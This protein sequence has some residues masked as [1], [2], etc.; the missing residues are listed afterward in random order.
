MGGSRWSSDDYQSYADT[1][2]YRTMSREQVFSHKVDEKLDPRNVK[3]GK[4]ERV[5]LQLRESIISEQNPNPTPIILGLD[6][7]GS[8]GMVAEQ[9]AKIEL[10]KLMTQIHETGV[11]SDPHVMF[12]GID[13]VFAQGHGALQTSYF[14]PDLQ[15]VEQLRKLWLV[16]NGGG[17]G[18]ESYD[19][20]WYFAGKHTYLDSY[21]KQGRKGF[22]FTFGDEPAPYQTVSVQSLKTIFG[23]KGDYE[24]MT[25]AAS[26]ASA[27]Q[28][29]NVFH[30]AIE[31]GG[32]SRD[33]RSSWTNML[34]SNVIFLKDT[35]YL[36]EVVI[37]T[38][39]IAQGAN[40]EA[41]IAESAC[42]QVLTYAFSN[43][44]KG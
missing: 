13:D 34:G 32:S 6:V 44:L 28:K 3:V 5:G 21:E 37:A 36:T 42:P 17:N 18:S 43:G 24:S 38:M 8:M 10:P 7:T 16:G 11:V 14:E 39:A 35:Q 25:P 29:F 4:G 26:L 41:V 20:A 15:I 2:S 19:L 31:K 12:M 30:I 9:I 40:I 1:T 27:Q 22:L 33:T 23:D